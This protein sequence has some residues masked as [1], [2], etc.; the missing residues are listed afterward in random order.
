MGKT[1]K[2]RQS[3]RLRQ[4]TLLFGGCL[5]IYC[6][7]F[8]YRNP[9]DDAAAV[10]A[11]RRP[12]HR[13]QL[14]PSL[15]TNL[16]LTEEQCNAAF[17]GLTREIDLAVAQGPFKV[18]QSGSLGPLQGRIKNGKVCWQPVI[19]LSSVKLTM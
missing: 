10:A 17:P 3:R 16:S 12:A 19:Q 1:M 4:T 2:V 5:A 6:L 8:V 7:L 11:T 14:S 18:K 15:L 9:V 13:E